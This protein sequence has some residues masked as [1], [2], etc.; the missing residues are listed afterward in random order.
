MP[1]GVETTGKEQNGT[2]VKTVGRT[3]TAILAIIKEN[4]HV[5]RPELSKKTGLTLRGVEWNLK[6][7]K[8]NGHIKR[9]GPDKGGYWEVIK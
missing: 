3:K 8:E 2:V 5:T 6:N 9:V 7:L 1:Q 4:P